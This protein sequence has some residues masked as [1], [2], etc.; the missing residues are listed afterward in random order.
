MESFSTVEE[1]FNDIEYYEP[2]EDYDK[3]C[4]NNKKNEKLRAICTFY[5]N[6]MKENIIDKLLIKQ[7]ILQLFN[8]LNNMISDGTKKNELDE[9]FFDSIYLDATFSMCFM[10]LYL[11]VDRLVVLFKLVDFIWTFLECIVGFIFHLYV[12]FR[13]NCSCEFV[14]RSWS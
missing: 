9:Y 5:V 14:G 7:T 4:E 12:S 3:F 11:W 13:W 1:R 6:L 10:V 8:I 2:E